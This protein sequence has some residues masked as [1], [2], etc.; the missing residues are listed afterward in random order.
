MKYSK[1]LFHVALIICSAQ[2]LLEASD[3]LATYSYPE[4]IVA[5][6]VVDDDGTPHTVQTRR[7]SLYSVSVS[8]GT[9]T[10]EA[11]VMYTPNPHTSGNLALNSSTHWTNFSFSGL[12]TVTITSLAGPINSVEIFPGAKGYVAQTSGNTATFTINSADGDVPL[13]LL[14][15]INDNQDQPLLIFADPP[16]TDIPDRAD[17]ENVA[18]IR[19]T[20]DIATVRSILTGPKPIIV[21]EEGIHQWGSDKTASYPGY[22]LPYLSNR[23][24]YIPGGA[25]VVGTFDGDGITN[26]RVYGRG[27]LSANGL[28]RLKGPDFIPN[29]F[30]HQ[31][32]EATNQRVEGLVCLD[33]PHFHLVFRGEVIVDN[34]KMIGYWHQT[35]GTVT[36]NNSVIQ[37]CF[38]KTNDDIM[39]LYSDHCYHENNTIMQLTNGAPF[40]FSWGSQNGD[41]NTVI[42]TYIIHA[43]YL[44]GVN[45]R[46]NTAVICARFGHDSISEN[47]SWDGI[48]IDNGIQ[49]LLGLNAQSSEKPNTIFRNFTIRNVFLNTGSADSPQDGAS[50][51]VDG[52]SFNFQNIRVENLFIDGDPIITFNGGGDL[53][54]DSSIWFS[55]GGGF[56]TFD[57]AS[58]PSAE[59]VITH[60]NAP[61][62]R[63]HPM[64][65][66]V[67]ADV[68]IQIDSEGNASLMSA[69]PSPAW[70]AANAGLTSPDFDDHWAVTGTTDVASAFNTS[71][72]VRLSYFAGIDTA[73]GLGT[74]DAFDLRANTLGIGVSGGPDANFTGSDGA[75][76]EGVTIGLDT[77][78]LGP[79]VHVGLNAVTIGQSDP[80]VDYS[81]LGFFIDP[82]SAAKINLVANPRADLASLELGLA[83]GNSLTDI[84]TL[85]EAVPAENGFRHL[86]T[87]LLLSAVSGASEEIIGAAADQDVTVSA[88]VDLTSPG[89][90]AGVFTRLGE[91]GQQYRFSVMQ[92]AGDLVT[93]LLRINASGDVTVLATS[94]IPLPGTAKLQL[95]LSA[96]GDFMVGRINGVKVVAAF[97]NAFIAGR[98]GAFTTDFGATFLTPVASGFL[99]DFYT[100]LME[101]DLSDD[102]TPESLASSGQPLLLYYIA[103][104]TPAGLQPS[105]PNVAFTELP[106]PQPRLNLNVR[107]SLRD[108]A[109]LIWA[110]ADLVQWHPVASWNSETQA[111]LSALSAEITTSANPDGS[112][113]VMIPP[114]D[115]HDAGF[116][117]L[118]A[119]L[120]EGV[121]PLPTEFEDFE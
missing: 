67:W 52:N 55:S 12:V 8:L 103:D 121:D 59:I 110:S 90:S 32:G 46:V 86:T 119:R 88:D 94:S 84:T 53:P 97:D 95:E 60:G 115:G 22:R 107:D 18:V 77:S 35:D 104:E 43:V 70:A 71:F 76:S 40:Q 83:G 10:Q 51:L 74:S 72:T 7:S 61:N 78:N 38:F 108:V 15:W 117:R 63:F 98:Q 41:N 11:Y 25:F 68:Q 87:R 109:L 5:P 24:I 96:N 3:S 44:P 64:S 66:P 14:L 48:Y 57:A 85:I 89:V 114:L 31:T 28:N 56:V 23:S 37:N 92:E 105:H 99:G 79:G 93:S 1:S 106:L 30:V 27:V 58:V 2:P 120:I 36:G 49:R 73:T 91:N 20:D 6:T 26:T 16:E 69:T 33:P 65:G 9:Q 101:N 34:V 62:T 81:T 42:D 4:V 112:I 100:W 118:D 19:T 13:Q 47:N 75:T 80:G 111:W 54:N 21:F 82:G 39:K 116:W 102:L 17:T 29:A 45:E 50:Y 113:S